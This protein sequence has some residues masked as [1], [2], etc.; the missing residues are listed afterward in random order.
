MH[1]S[2]ANFQV[3]LPSKITLPKYTRGFHLGSSR[4]RMKSSDVE[5]TSSAVLYT[6]GGDKKTRSTVFS[7]IYAARSSA[8]SQAGFRTFQE[9]SCLVPVA[10]CHRPP[11][12]LALYHRTL[13]RPRHIE[14]TRFRPAEE[15]TSPHEDAYVLEASS[16]YA[17]T[18]A[19]VLRSSWTEMH[20]VVCGD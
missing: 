10:P 20:L 2:N 15:V 16:L 17:L 3:R 12:S 7:R 4:L 19:Y 13:K 1:F 8:R 11:H 5:H 14:D 18:F 6:V 9:A